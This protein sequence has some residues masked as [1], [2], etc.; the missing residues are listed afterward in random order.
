MS[1]EE[2]DEQKS[3]VR[4][5]DERGAYDENLEEITELNQHNGAAVAIEMD[6][7]SLGP[8]AAYLKGTRE[9]AIG[10]LVDLIRMDPSDAVGIAV[11][12]EQAKC[13]TRAC[14][15]VT[16]TLEQGEQAQEYIKERYGDGEEINEEG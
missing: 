6:L 11:L 7:E 15:Y 4:L 10:A 14:E 3:Y 9:A 13:Y 2:D 5:Y 8:M 16:S 1:A 12:Q